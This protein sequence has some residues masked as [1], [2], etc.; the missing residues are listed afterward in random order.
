MI[1]ILQELH[2]KFVPMHIY[3]D[4]D[5]EHKEILEK[6]FFGGDQL[7]EERSR[8]VMYT[9]AVTVT[10]LMKNWKVLFLKWRTGIA[11]EFCIRYVSNAIHCILLFSPFPSIKP[12]SS[13]N[14]PFER[15]KI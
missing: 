13:I 14:P 9:L 5:T 10:T 12:P 7:T 4:D 1:D 3:T 15:K 11:F 6:I 2:D 8:N